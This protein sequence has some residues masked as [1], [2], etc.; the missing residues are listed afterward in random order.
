MPSYPW[1]FDQTINKD[2][3]AAKIKA[4]R[5]IGVPYAEGYEETANEDLQKQAD[6]IVSSLKADG[7]ETMSDAEIVAVISYLQRLGKD[8]KAESSFAKAT[9]DKK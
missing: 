5:K 1:L 3:T 9:E 7:I 2:Q 6:E 8:I 4:L